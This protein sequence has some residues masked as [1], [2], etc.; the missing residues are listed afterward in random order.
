MSWLVRLYHAVSRGKTIFDL[1]YEWR[2]KGVKFYG[3]KL[4]NTLLHTYSFGEGCKFYGLHDRG[5]YLKVGK[6]TTCTGGLEIAGGQGHEVTIGDYCVFGTN[7]FIASIN[8]PLEGPA[9]TYWNKR[10]D[11][12]LFNKLSPRAPVVIEDDVMVTHGG[13]ILKG[14]RMAR[15]TILS[16]NSVLASSTEPNSIYCGNPA[17]LIMRRPEYSNEEDKT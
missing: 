3:C 6:Y 15:G 14:V 4:Q 9:V 2:F 13:C 5:G 8:H 10:V 17:R 16:V 12:L 1:Y 7:T 11:P